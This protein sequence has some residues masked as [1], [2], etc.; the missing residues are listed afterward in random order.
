M[1]QYVPSPL[2]LSGGGVQIAE[3]PLLQGEIA[4]APLQGGLRLG[5]RAGTIPP[6]GAFKG[7]GSVTGGVV[8]GTESAPRR[9]VDPCDGGGI[10]LHH[11]GAVEDT[12]EVLPLHVAACVLPREGVT[13]GATTGVH[14][15][16]V[17]TLHPEVAEEVALPP[18]AAWLGAKEIAPLLALRDAREL[19]APL[20]LQGVEVHVGGQHAAAPAA[21][22]V[23]DAAPAA[24][25]H[26]PAPAAEA[27]ALAAAAAA[28]AAAPAA[29]LEVHAPKAALLLAPAAAVA[30][31]RALE[32]ASHPHPPPASPPPHQ[33]GAKMATFRRPP[34]AKAVALGGYPHLLAHPEALQSCLVCGEF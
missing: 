16:G 20:H 1:R 30:A 4:E 10:L 11:G 25:G 12:I 23:P 21:A 18:A 17:A 14:Q 34:N 2:N 26:A 27:S 33:V 32:P 13:G 31:A 15:D 9:T 7:T 28:G 3:A 6:E 5:V 24:P 19:A 22:A 29:H 8:T